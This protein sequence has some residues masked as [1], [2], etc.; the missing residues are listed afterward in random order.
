MSTPMRRKRCARAASGHVAAAPPSSVMN[1][2][3]LM[4]NMG[5]PPRRPKQSIA[6][7]QAG[8]WGRP[9]KR[10]DGVLVA[11]NVRCRSTACE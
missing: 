4:P 6:K 9:R 3:R 8:S 11:S 7:T 2:R 5:L 10:L 1:S